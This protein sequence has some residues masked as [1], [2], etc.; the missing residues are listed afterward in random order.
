M[1]TINAEAMA[2][3]AKVES[4]KRLN[5]YGILNNI[6]IA[7]QKTTFPYDGLVPQKIQFGKVA[8]INSLQPV[9]HVKHGGDASYAPIEF[10]E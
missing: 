1:A 2:E 5:I 3:A 9:K 10:Y 4:R 6:K 7:A 8:T